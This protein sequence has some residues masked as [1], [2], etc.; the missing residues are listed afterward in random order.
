MTGQRVIFCLE[1]VR[2]GSNRDRPG[3]SVD[4]K[5]VLMNYKDL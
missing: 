1:L 3:V 2:T 4:T 5:G